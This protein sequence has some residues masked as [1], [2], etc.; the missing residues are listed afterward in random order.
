M[1]TDD[2]MERR[3]QFRRTS[4]V[5]TIPHRIIRELKI[6]KG[7]SVR[8]TIGDGEFT[9]RPTDTGISKNPAKTKYENPVKTMLSQTDKDVA[10]MVR[11]NTKHSK[12]SKLD[13]LSI[14]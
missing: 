2:I 9:V 7:Q 13:K 6:S 4:F 3:I 1:M 8:F 11:K 10:E 14:K 5:L 12:I